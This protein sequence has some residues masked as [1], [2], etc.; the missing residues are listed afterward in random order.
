VLFAAC[1]SILIITTI[2]SYR[3]LQN[4]KQN[5]NQMEQSW[6]VNDHLKNINLLTG[7]VEDSLL[8]FYI[9]DDQAFLKPLQLAKE[10]LNAEFL[11]LG[12]LIDGNPNQ[13]KHLVELRTLF[14][15]RIE[16]FED[17][18][19]HFKRSKL[20]EVVEIVKRR[21]G[22]Q[23]LD[24][25][26][27]LE[28]TMEKDEVTQLTERRNQLY[29]E[30]D[31]TILFGAI[32]NGVAVFILIVFY[33]LIYQRFA[34]Q[35]AVEDALK[36]ANENL[37]ATVSK[38]TAKLSV[39]TRHLLRVSEVEKAKLARELHD[40]MGSS[41]T[42]IGMDVMIVSERLKDLQP[43]LANQLSRAKKTL[44]ET[45]EMKR[46]II[47]DLR[48]SMLDNLGLVASI[49]SHCEKV[50]RVPDLEYVEDIP[51][52][53]KNINPEWAIALFR[54][55]QEALNNVIKYAN[56]TRVKISLKRT[57]S[58]LWLQVL[59]NGIGIQEDAMDK[60]KSHGL[61][62]MR[63]RVLLLGGKFEIKSGA[64]NCGTAIEVLL[65]FSD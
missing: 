8:G 45:V 14:D 65:P 28:I 32:I 62:G 6:Y 34:K 52:E 23:I 3:D 42:A 48:P 11:A 49:R 54:I 12:K 29:K 21:E 64:A 40:E 63:E 20:K 36:Q 38:R 61:L 5:I 60:P 46:R 13:Q 50:I 41:L 43:D 35:R 55:V 22:M 4:L 10:N 19:A 25:V 17:R 33:R 16:K 37:E 26:R 47:E 53:I 39:L 9:S 24:E 7:N 30:F 15:K 51:E 59:D 18:V 27:Q 58:G 2:S 57:L 31:R 56:A 1:L 44:Q